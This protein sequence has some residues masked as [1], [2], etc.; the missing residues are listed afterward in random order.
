MNLGD[1]FD[2]HAVIR[3]EIMSEYMQHVY[4]VIKKHKYVYLLGNHDMFKP[5]DA[6][7]HALLPYKHKFDNFI[8]V[9]KPTDM[10]GISFIPYMHN[11]QDFPRNPGQPIVVA[12]QT[13]VGADYG[14]YR[15]DVGVDADKVA[16][17]IIIS[18]H[19]HK[20]Q[21]FGKVHYPGTPFAQGLDD[22]NQ[23]KGLTVFDKSTYGFE[24]LESPFPMWKGL[25]LVVDDEHNI[26]DIHDHLCSSVN[27]KDHWVVELTGPKAEIVSYLDSKKWHEL[28]SKHSIRVKPEYN[29]KSKISNKKIKSIT[30]Q[31]I[32]CEYVDNI[33]TGSLD[34]GL[35]KE[36]ALQVLDT[37]SKK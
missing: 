8:V 34:K 20:R 19:V 18:G 11:W 25:R 31:D 10:F 9:D 16:A 21:S 3:S 23:V 13:F 35:I 37:T 22:I 5:D 4:R 30:M 17:E 32:V 27:A 14:Y 26:N 2:T 24:F 1:T 6:T 28:V 33:Y 36:K 7:Y 29:D 15:P 12:H